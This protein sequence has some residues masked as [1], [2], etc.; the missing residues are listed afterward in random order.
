MS[1]KKKTAKT[2]LHPVTFDKFIQCGTDHGIPP[3]MATVLKY[4][5]NR[6]LK[7][8]A[9]PELQNVIAIEGGTTWSFIEK[10][11]YEALKRRGYL[12]DKGN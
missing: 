9:L 3:R 5:I 12:R 10:A 1:I 8:N 11:V 7:L 6:L 2:E 4:F